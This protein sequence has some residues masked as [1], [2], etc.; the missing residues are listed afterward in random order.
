MFVDNAVV[1]VLPFGR[2]LW[3]AYWWAFSVVTAAYQQR[4]WPL[5][6]RRIT[7]RLPKAACGSHFSKIPA[8]V[9]PQPLIA[10]RIHALIC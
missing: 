4:P 8:R 9:M 2:A 3:S 7:T 5:R 6:H 10:A 1:K